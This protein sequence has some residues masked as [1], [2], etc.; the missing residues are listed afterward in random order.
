M[1]KR[2]KFN[3]YTMKAEHITL[4]SKIIIVILVSGMFLG[5]LHLSLLASALKPEINTMIN[6]DIERHFSCLDKIEEIN[7]LRTP[8]SKTY[9]K[10]NGMYETEYYEEIIHYKKNNEW[11]EIDNSLELKTN[12]RYENNSN[13]YNISFPSKLNKNNEIILS[14]LNNDIKIYYQTNIDVFAK[15]NHQIDR[16]KNNLKDEIIYELNSNES[17]QY[18]VKQDSIKENII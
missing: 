8:N 6:E 16:T 5:N 10:E 17:I 2:K 13:Q 9:L 3:Y 4:F 11:I 1:K 18:I 14:Y 12:S 15:L 7:E